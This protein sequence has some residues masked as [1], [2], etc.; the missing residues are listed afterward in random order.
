VLRGARGGAKARGAGASAGGGGGG[1]G[2]AEGGEDA[3]AGAAEGGD[4]ERERGGREQFAR[5]LGSWSRDDDDSPDVWRRR[6]DEQMARVAAWHA[7]LLA[8]EPPAS[9]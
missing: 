4:F 1:G 8:E 9:S 3:G 6:H 5:A 7:E 2:G